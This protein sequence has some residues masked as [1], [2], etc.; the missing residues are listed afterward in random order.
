MPTRCLLLYLLLAPAVVPAAET[1]VHRWV[2][3][4]GRVHYSDRP[5]VE[6]PVETPV[7]TQVIETEAGIAQE[8]AHPRA[9]S[10]SSSAA[11][12]RARRGTQ[13]AREREQQLARCQ[14]LEET[15]REVRERRRRPHDAA[16]GQRLRERSAELTREHRRYCSG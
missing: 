12:A 10:R 4:E 2:D 9:G 1:T 5:P 6:G 11:R 16:T 13:A 14:E 15:M 8:P 3:A 7:E